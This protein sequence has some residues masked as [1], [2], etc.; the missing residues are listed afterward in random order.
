MNAKI[1]IAVALFLCSLAVRTIYLYDM[2]SGPYFVSPQLDELNFDLQARRIAFEGVW[3]SDGVFSRGPLYPVFL[4]ACYK[5]F[6]HDYFIPR[7]IQA[8]VGSFGVVFLYLI[9]RRVFGPWTGLAGAALGAVWPTMIFFDGEL[10]IESWAVTLDLFAL[11]LILR[12]SDRPARLGRMAVAGA[13]CG[14]SALARPNIL[15]ATPFFAL[16]G[17]WVCQYAGV[18]WRRALAGVAL[19]A[20][21]MILVLLP[22]TLHNAIAGRDFVLISSQGGINFYVGNNANATGY[23]SATPRRFPY[24]TEYEDSVDLFARTQAESDTGRKMKPSEVSRYWSRKAWA[25]ISA[26]P[27]SAAA[28]TLKKTVL[29]WSAAEIGDDKSVSFASRFSRLLGV[30][31]WVLPF[32]VVAPL[33]L[34]QAVRRRRGAPKVLLAGFIWFYMLSVIPFFVYSRY[35]M[36]VVPILLLFTVRF[37]VEAWRATARGEWKAL[38]LAFGLATGFAVIVWV[39]FYGLHRTMQER[40]ANDYWI[41]ANG[42]MLSGRYDQAADFY[43]EAIARRPTYTEAWLNL[44]KTLC[45]AKRFPE[46]DHVFSKV[47]ELDPENARAMSNRALCLVSMGRAEEA[48]TLWRKSLEAEP[49][50]PIALTEFAQFLVDAERYDEARPLLERAHI[51][52]SD[53]IEPVLLLVR[54]L[55]ATGDQNAARVWTDIAQKIDPEKTAKELARI[56][57]DTK[58]ADQP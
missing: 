21:A 55:E 1:R 26:H 25:W 39:D 48:E 49:H 18:A 43:Q 14:L 31:V 17:L 4:A 11:L 22:A 35:R 28:L 9:G 32:G 2:S 10:L 38:K 37:V 16:W 24:W 33:G 56:R 42:Y 44:G 41:A 8:V 53:N 45:L 15:V 5:T 23:S 58:P 20:L 52:D 54:L 50:N 30:L 34:A 36:P 27:F 29:F 19:A 51:V 46:A 7:A 3:S 13:A 6:G 12:W 47:L 57:T 40:E